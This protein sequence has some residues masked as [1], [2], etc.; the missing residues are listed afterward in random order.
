MANEF[1]QI[2]RAEPFG[3]GSYLCHTQKLAEMRNGRFKKV[4]TLASLG[5]MSVDEKSVILGQWKA[6]E[7][8]WQSTWE[9]NQSFKA[10]QPGDAGLPE[11][12]FYILD[13][14][15]YPSGEGLHVGHPLGYIAT[16]IL[17]R[18][19][20]M[21][22]FNVLHPMGWDAFGL[23]AEQYAIQKGIHPELTTKKNIETYKRQLRSIG[24]SYDWSREI[25]TTDPTYYKWTQWIFKKLI[26]RGLAYQAEVAVN[27]CPELGT[28]LANDEVIDG[29]SERGGH[30][31]IRRPMRQWM[32]RITEYAERLLSDLESLD[33]P[34]S[35]KDLQRNWI[36]KSEGAQLRFSL[37]ENA[38]SSLE[39]FT[40][41]PD[42]LMGVT[43]MV[44]A[45]EH[46]LLTQLVTTA[47]KSKVEEYIREAAKKSDLQ[48]T[49]LA[50]T[51]T[52]VF[53]GGYCLHP[54]TGKEIPVW[55]ADYVL[56]SYGTGAIMA[57]PAH[58]E[59]DKEFA[60]TFSLPIAE[61]I[62]E[63]GKM[64]HSN[65]ADLEVNGLPFKEGA[66]K[67]LSYLEGKKLGE[68]K[69]T[70]KLRD[71]VFSRQRYWGEPI[72]VLLDSKEPLKFEVLADEA[73]PV[74]LPAVQSY[75]PTGTGDSPLAAVKDWVKVGDKLRETNT[76]PG[77]AGSSW[78]WLRYMD[79]QN[80]KEFVSK[81]AEQY[82]GPVDFDMG[83]AE[84][85][86]GHLLYSRFWHKVLFD[87][88]LVST[89]EPF[90]KLVH[91]GLMQGEDGEKMSK[92]RGNVVNPDQVI[93]DYG[94]DT[95]RLFEMF[96]GPI[97]KSKP[98]QTASIEG[99]FRFLL[100][101]WKLSVDVETGAL[102]SAVVDLP[103]EKWDFAVRHILHKTIKSVTEDFERLSFNTAISSLMIC[104][105]ELN[106]KMPGQ[107]PKSFLSRVT[108]LLAPLAPHIAEELWSKL[109]NKN[110][111]SHESW[112]TYEAKCVELDEVLIVVQI[113]GKLRDRVTVSRNMSEAD[114][115][116]L[117]LKM[118]SVVEKTQGQVLKKLIVVPNKLVNIV[119]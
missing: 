3:Q 46:P 60:E 74:T 43:F 34:E 78:Y 24:L 114:L 48:R 30:P 28:V 41:R 67:I 73:L 108:L 17:S 101:V 7:E 95:F 84:H 103:E 77:S 5:P 79:P 96:L 51:K 109:G 100:K 105:N 98:W 116:E 1:G 68:K 40:T 72:P 83:G 57:V 63:D 47:Q 25:N 26:E 113:N 12:K 76:M 38:N 88:G 37:K 19:K 75:Q 36:G 10:K 16:D 104:F 110:S 32:M 93:K 82:W 89:V 62:T 31:V 23:P 58:D 35:T 15:P 2:L 42:T 119:V 86:V 87:M 39:V 52:G 70:Y 102:S 11:K 18:Y 27:W 45:P 6:A 99:V 91:Q 118:P 22:G 20:R 97:E 117:V 111:L 53:T 4:P 85:A 112:P 64:I 94:S 66:E 9:K 65:F 13:M 14:F 106:E 69:I 56:I 81:E 49:D 33:W 59:R 50:K 61:V 115:K 107:I 29:K 90:T 8:K 55:V 54:L 21:Q 80:S 71:W 92:S 44:V